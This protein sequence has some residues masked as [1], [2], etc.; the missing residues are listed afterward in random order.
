MIA[1]E[2][3][4]WRVPDFGRL[5]AEGFRREG[6][7]YVRGQDLMDGQFRLTVQ[8]PLSGQVRTTLTDGLTGEPYTLYLVEEAAGEFV[9]SVREE[10]RRALE[11][12]ASRGFVREVFR[13]GQTHA[14]IAHVRE[15]YGDGP[16]YLWEKFPDNAVFRRR[17]NGKWYGAVLTT[18]KE[19]L[20]MAGEG[21]IEILDLRADPRDA[22]LL[23][24][25][26]RIFKGWHM[27]KKHWIS[28]P[29]DGTLSL[30]EIAGLLE[31]SYLIAGRKAV[32]V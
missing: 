19:K 13:S 21:R 2:V 26:V 14:L 4:K 9:G 29:L 17:D 30:E 7:A 18:A 1:D 16:E 32:R 24:D 28:L 20:G 22:E 27:N 25:G 3:F 12:I 8:I 15:K 6:E 31:E 5:Q 10:V 23:V 11:E